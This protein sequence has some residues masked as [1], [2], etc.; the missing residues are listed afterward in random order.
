M[1]KKTEIGVVFNTCGISGDFSDRYIKN[2]EA[3]LSQKSRYKI[4]IIQSDCKSSE[5]CRNKVRTKIGSR[6]LYNYI[7]DKLPVN[8]TFNFSA[9]KLLEAYPKIEWIVYSESAITLERQDIDKLLSCAADYIGYMSGLVSLD[10]NL[11]PFVQRGLISDGEDTN[12]LCETYPNQCIGLDIGDSVSCHLMA[13]NRKV[14][15]EF[16]GGLPDIFAGFC[17]ES[18]LSFIAASLGLI[19]VVNTKVK[20]LHEIEGD[21]RSI[22]FDPASNRFDRAFA[23]P[24]VQGRILECVKYGLGYEECSNIIMHDASLFDGRL[25]IYQAELRECIKQNLF[26]QDKEFKYS[27]IKHIIYERGSWFCRV[28]ERFQRLIRK[29]YGKRS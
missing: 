25:P 11:H 26:L 21:G 23:I 19:W 7:N 27:D 18:V 20:V 3:L 16:G 9:R 4:H 5:E 8:L 29:I 13:I 22:G 14:F 1:F 24:G 15:D 6:I 28:K 17:S 2:L 12:K 10:N